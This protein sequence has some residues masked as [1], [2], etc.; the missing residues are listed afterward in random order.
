MVEHQLPKLNMGVRFPFPAPHRN[1]LCSFRFFISQKNQSPASLF[2]LFRK[3]S[4]SRRLFACK[5]AH[6]GFGSL[7]TFCGDAGQLHLFRSTLP[8]RVSIWTLGFLL[9]PSGLTKP[10]VLPGVNKK[11]LGKRK[12]KNN[13]C[14][15]KKRERHRFY[16]RNAGIFAES[17]PFAE[18]YGIPKRTG[19]PVAGQAM[20]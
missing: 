3:R 15:S 16:E 11:R 19:L 5:R 8:V 2:F 9:L 12:S 6:D 13:V 10:L 14:P 17:I 1:E 7:P 20:R 18:C 4:R